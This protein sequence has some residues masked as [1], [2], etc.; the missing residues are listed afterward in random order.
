MIVV[1][2]PKQLPPTVIDKKCSELGYGISWLARTYN[3]MPKQVHLLNVQYRMDKS[4]LNFPNKQFYNKQIMSGDS[5]VGREPYVSK[6]NIFVD[7]KGNG[8][9]EKN[10]FSWKNEYEAVVIKSIL[11]TNEDIVKLQSCSPQAR[12]IIISPYRAQVCL[13]SDQFKKV[14]G[15][16]VTTVDSVQGNEADIVILSTV[17][18]K[19]PGFVDDG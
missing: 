12:T 16:D 18:T 4:I 1:G 2:D 9:E 7:T 17:R 11:N 15:V 13:I 6:P 19:R 3:Q 14:R 5:V 10:Q 8:R